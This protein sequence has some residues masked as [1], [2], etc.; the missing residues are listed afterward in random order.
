MLDKY[1]LNRCNKIESFE[2]PDPPTVV[3]YWANDCIPISNIE[4]MVPI[5][6]WKQMEEA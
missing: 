3:R 5:Q 4:V 1:K 2:I 6:D